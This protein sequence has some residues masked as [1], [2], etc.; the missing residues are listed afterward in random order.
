[1][2]GID[3]TAIENKRA[4]LPPRSGLAN[5]FEAVAREWLVKCKRDGLTPVTIEKT[6]CSLLAP[7]L[8]RQLAISQITLHEALAVL[9]Q[10]NHAFHI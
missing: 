8:P 3:D 6:S 1:M 4:E 2:P 9:R 7:P 10:T 5:T